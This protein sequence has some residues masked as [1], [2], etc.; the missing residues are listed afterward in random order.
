MNNGDN[1]NAER[2]PQRVEERVLVPATDVC[3]HDDAL[4]LL[5]DMPGVNRDSLTLE[6][7]D[8][9]LTV[10]GTVAVAM[11]DEL[12][13]TFAEL[14]A[15]RYVRRF[16]LGDEIDAEAI[17]AVM[18]DGVLRLRMPKKPTHQRRRIEVAGA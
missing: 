17:E 1:R 12:K 9:V 8:G 13:A 18:R 4:D 6:V 16:S 2:K 15:S 10:D 3:E 11:P 5:V 7:E 14:R